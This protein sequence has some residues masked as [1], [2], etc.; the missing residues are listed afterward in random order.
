VLVVRTVNT[1]IDEGRAALA[2]LGMDKA[3][4]PARGTDADAAVNL[5]Y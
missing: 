3:P 5:S 2:E 4:F 1:S